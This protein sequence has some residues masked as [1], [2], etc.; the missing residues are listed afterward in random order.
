MQFSTIFTLVAVFLPAIFAT[1]TTSNYLQYVSYTESS[2]LAQQSVISAAVNSVKAGES[3]YLKSLYASESAAASTAS[4]TLL[5]SYLSAT[6]VA[7][8]VSSVA[9]TIK[10]S[11]SSAEITSKATSTK[12]SSEESASESFSQSSATVSVNGSTSAADSIKLSNEAS[13]KLMI[14]PL[15]MIIGSISFGL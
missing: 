9:A 13:R 1:S 7:S 10:A 2:V 11:G 15:V 3:T 4:T 8:D 6:S 14:V 12:S 5:T